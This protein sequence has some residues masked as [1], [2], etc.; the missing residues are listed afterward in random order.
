MLLLLSVPRDY[1]VYIA[2]LTT[3]PL[4][5]ALQHVTVMAPAVHQLFML[6]ITYLA[7]A[8]CFLAALFHLLRGS[9]LR[10]RYEVVPGQPA[11]ILLHPVQMTIELGVV[12]AMLGLLGGIYDAASF[13]LLFVIAVLFGLGLRLVEH[14]GQGREVGVALRSLVWL[15]GVSGAACVVLYLFASR[16]FGAGM[17]GV[18]YVAAVSAVVVAL[19]LVVNWRLVWM[20]HG[21]WKDSM[22]GEQWFMI[23][24]FAGV[25][26]LS[27][28]LF[29][30]LLRP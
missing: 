3:D 26:L 9:V 30:L 5:S 15:S 21:K 7:A 22:T 14:Q 13:L 6:N 23:V 25:T 10:K 4:Q 12:L 29:V 28:E 27:A 17:P 1:P 11:R 19:L 18:V 8:L 24:N 20:K 16:T 2:H